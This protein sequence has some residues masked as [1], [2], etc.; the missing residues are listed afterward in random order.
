MVSG[1]R[2]LWEYEHPYGCAEGNWFANGWHREYESWA[3]FLDDHGP[4]D[5][6]LNLVWRWDWESERDE[7]TDE[8]TDRPGT[9]LRLHIVQQRKAILQSVDVKVTPDDEPAVREFLAKHGT[10]IAALWAGVLR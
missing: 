10:K 1:E 3:D 5:V 9:T 8:P 6:D 4:S 7:E 2:H